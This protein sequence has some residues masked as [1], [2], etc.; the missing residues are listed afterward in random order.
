MVTADTSGLPPCLPAARADCE[1]AELARL[2]LENERLRI[3]L[4]QAL[5]AMAAREVIEQA[6][7]LLMGYYRCSDEQAFAALREV[8]QRCNVKLRALAMDIVG[9]ARRSGRVHHRGLDDVV[10]A[11]LAGAEPG[12]AAGP[13]PAATDPAACAD[14]PAGWR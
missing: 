5:R 9:L 7:G 4:E 8:S 11:V 10:Q 2:R 1:S 6:K 13:P 12:I 3:E 14:R